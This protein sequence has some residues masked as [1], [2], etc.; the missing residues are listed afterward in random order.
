MAPFQIATVYAYRGQ[1]NETLEWLER[2]YVV[3][4]T[5]LSQLKA[6][7]E[8]RRFEHEPRYLAFL[9][10]MALTSL[11]PQLFGCDHR[12]APRSA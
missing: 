12:S 3:R 7:P 8:F 1:L 5:G 4:D 2:S 9:D 6:L 11:A 10:K